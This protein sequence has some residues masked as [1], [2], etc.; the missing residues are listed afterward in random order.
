MEGASYRIR[1]SGQELRMSALQGC[2]VY[3]LG[4]TVM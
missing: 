2:K 1:E 3:G 4:Y